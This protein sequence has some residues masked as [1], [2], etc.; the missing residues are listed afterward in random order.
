MI[1]VCVPETQDQFNIKN[2]ICKDCGYNN[3][4]WGQQLTEDNNA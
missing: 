1:F 2:V 3:R 4:P